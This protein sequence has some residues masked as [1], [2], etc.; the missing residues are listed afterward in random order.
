MAALGPDGTLLHG[1]VGGR[2]RPSAFALMRDEGTLAALARACGLARR[3]QWP[4]RSSAGFQFVS[5]ARPQSRACSDRYRPLIGASRSV[6]GHAAGAAI[7]SQDALAFSALSGVRP[8]IETMPLPGAGG[9]C[10]DDAR[11]RA[12]PLGADYGVVWIKPVPATIIH[13]RF[14]VRAK[15]NL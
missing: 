1:S 14:H 15:S 8:M 12:L 7:G 4:P 9:L 11:R 6:V 3:Q 10:A 5:A 2:S 13:N